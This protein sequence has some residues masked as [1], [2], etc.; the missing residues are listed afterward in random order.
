LWRSTDQGWVLKNIQTLN[1]PRS[2][3]KSIIIK[4]KEYGTITN[5]PREGRT[6]KLTDQARRALIREATKRPNITLKEL[7]IST[8]DIAVCVHR[9]TLSRTLH[10]A[11]LYSRMARKKP[12]LKEKNKQ[13]CL[14]FTKSYVGDSPNI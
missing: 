2:T 1:I 7:Q 4:L 5:L 12:L 3:I 11:G 10:R 8:A 9:T 6:P 14:V 13:T